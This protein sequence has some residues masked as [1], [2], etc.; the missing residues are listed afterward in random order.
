MDQ[1]GDLP[2][3]AQILLRVLPRDVGCRAFVGHYP[4]IL[5]TES[6]GLNCRVSDDGFLQGCV[7]NAEGVGHGVLL[8]DLASVR[9]GAVDSSVR[10]QFTGRSDLHSLIQGVQVVAHHLVKP[11]QYVPRLRMS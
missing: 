6:D 11:G 9:Q 4:A 2:G 5:G 3:D 10:I 8:S 1:G 7:Y